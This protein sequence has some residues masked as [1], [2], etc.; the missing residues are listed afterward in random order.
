LR[1]RIGVLDKVPH[2]ARGLSASDMAIPAAAWCGHWWDE[3]VA[4]LQAR[5]CGWCEAQPGACQR[6]TATRSRAVAAARRGSRTAKVHAH[7]R[8]PTKAALA[9][10]RCVEPV[11][12]DLVAGLNKFFS[13]LPHKHSRVLLHE[14]GDALVTAEG[15]NEPA[16]LILRIA[17]R[18]QDTEQIQPCNSILMVQL[19]LSAREDLRDGKRC[20]DRRR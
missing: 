19:L 10:G 12:F 2:R 3:E 15:T 14:P 20:S 1:S 17:D 6:R 5:G 9:T 7:I 4:A 8:C 16:A 18:P 13:H 11:E